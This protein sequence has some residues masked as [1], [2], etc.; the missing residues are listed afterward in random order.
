RGGARGVFCFSQE[1]I[2]WSNLR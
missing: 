2:M 1:N